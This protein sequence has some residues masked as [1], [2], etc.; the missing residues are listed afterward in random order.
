MRV[1]IRDTEKLGETRAALAEALAASGIE[2]YRDLR[3]LTWEDLRGNMLSAVHIEKFIIYF[4]L[5]FVVSFTA[6]MVFL[7][8]FL[9]VIEKTR[10][11]GILMALGTTP[12]GVV[13]I[14]LTN[15]IVLSAAGTVLGL[16]LGYLFCIYINPIHDWIYETTGFRLFPAEIY[17]MDRI[18]TQFS[19]WDVLLSVTPPI[20]LGFLASILPARWAARR[21]PIKA[22]HYE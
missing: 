5:L 6:C 1:S 19:F 8:L 15:G 17:H 14:F 12:S 2:A 16:I 18:P 13:K 10:D 7:M 20:V 9:T 21:D 11:V 4:L 3:V 22:I